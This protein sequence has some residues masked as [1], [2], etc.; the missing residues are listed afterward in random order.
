VAVEIWVRKCSSFEEERQADREFW[1]TMTGDAR[2]SAVDE[3]RAEWATTSGHGHEGLRR[4]V[5]RIQRPAR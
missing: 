1:A 3:L 4:T 2:V 5:R